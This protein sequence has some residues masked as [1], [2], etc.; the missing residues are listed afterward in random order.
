MNK[1]SRLIDATLAQLVNAGKM[2]REIRVQEM[3]TMQ[4]MGNTL[5]EVNKAEERGDMPKGE[6]ARAEKLALAI[7]KLTHAAGN[8]G[9]LAMAIAGAITQTR[10]AMEEFGEILEAMDLDW[11][12]EEE[13]ES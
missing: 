4:E 1:T 9:L 12:E 6:R 3:V 10:L 5:D 7:L 8:A 13:G 11:D 2:P